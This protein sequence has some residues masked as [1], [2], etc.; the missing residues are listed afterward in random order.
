MVMLCA[1]EDQKKE[2]VTTFLDW[3]DGE[4]F[5]V[6]GLGL[7]LGTGDEEDLLPVCDVAQSMKMSWSHAD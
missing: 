7:D 1:G 4:S 2:V 6:W 3:A 5:S